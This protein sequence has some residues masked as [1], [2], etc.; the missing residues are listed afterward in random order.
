LIGVVG[1]E[2]EE[3][4]SKICFLMWTGIEAMDGIEI[5]ATDIVRI[6]FHQILSSTMKRTQRRHNSAR[7]LL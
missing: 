7:M 3:D 4:A 1:A 2:K 5:E 6:V